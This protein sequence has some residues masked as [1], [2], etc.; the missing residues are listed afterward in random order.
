AKS[1]TQPVQIRHNKM[2]KPFEGQFIVGEMNQERLVRIMLEDVNGVVQGAVTP[3]IDGQ[4]L[5]KGNNRL[6]IAPDGSL[7][8]GQSDHGWLGDRGI[9]KITA[10]NKVPFDVKDVKLNKEGFD[11]TFTK[12]FSIPK[13][14]DLSSWLKIKKYHYHYH[15]KYGSDRVDEQEVV[16]KGFKSKAGNTKLSLQLGE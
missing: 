15:A 13:G 2:L 14:T 10:T 7:W 3:F 11:L 12:G 4:G 6:A 16:V 5:R 9:Q 8:V 1:H